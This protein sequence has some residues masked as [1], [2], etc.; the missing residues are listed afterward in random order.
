MQNDNISVCDNLN[1]NNEIVDLTQNNIVV[2]DGIDVIYEYF[3]ANNDLIADPTNFLVTASPTTVT[4]TVKN[5]SEN[6]F[7]T[8]ELTIILNPVLEVEDA[9]LEL[10]SESGFATFHLPNANN[11]IYQNTENVEFQYYLNFD[12]A[13]EGDV[14]NA[15]ADDFTNTTNPQTVYARV[16]DEN[17]CFNIAE[18][19]L[20]VAIGP[21]HIPFEA[22]VCD[23][24]GDGFAEFDLTN[25]AFNLLVGTG[26][27]IEFN[28]YLDES[29]TKKSII[30]NYIN[31]SNPQIIYVSMYDTTAE[32]ACLVVEELTLTV[33]EFP[34]TQNDNITICDNLNDNSE[35]VDLTQNNIVVSTGINVSYQYFLKSVEQKL[36]IPKF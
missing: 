16:M 28:Y 30:R 35:I 14:N 20:N 23:D 1:D 22:E 6:C 15:L 11:D 4:V 3:D 5:N 29:L 10:C 33:N 9:E 27:N 36:P 18:I 2:T 24:D 32:E 25:L 13:F 12:Q 21:D 31:I 34:E 8:K 17:G 7:E 19:E 26:E